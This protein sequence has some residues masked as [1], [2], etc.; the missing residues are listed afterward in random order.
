MSQYQTIQQH[1]W[2]FK[3]LFF[4]VGIIYE[5]VEAGK[6]LIA[7]EK[8][9]DKLKKELKVRIKEAEQILRIEEEGSPYH[10]LCSYLQETEKSF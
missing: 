8:G 10:Q 2:K 7:K 3:N 9:S 5:F 1:F 4:L 6:A